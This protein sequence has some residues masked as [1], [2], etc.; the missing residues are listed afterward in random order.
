MERPNP[1]PEHSSRILSVSDRDS[2]QYRD[3]GPGERAQGVERD[4][5][6]ADPNYAAAN[7]VARLRTTSIKPWHA[8]S[9]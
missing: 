7:M 5:P 1:I 6:V 3:V 4:E 9:T 8:S 2:Q